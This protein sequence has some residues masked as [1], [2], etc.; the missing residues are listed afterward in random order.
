MTRR[1][2]LGLAVTASLLTGC[3]ADP[4]APVP[5]PEKQSRV[6]CDL[7]FP[8]PATVSPPVAAAR[9]AVEMRSR[10]AR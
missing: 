3:S 1:L 2:L 5:V 9:A 4:P 6:H 8:A 10:H 7:I